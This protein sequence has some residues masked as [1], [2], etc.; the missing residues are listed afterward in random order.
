MAASG[1]M[2]VLQVIFLGVTFGNLSLVRGSATDSNRL[3]RLDRPL[4]SM[5]LPSSLCGHQAG[6]RPVQLFP[7][8]VRRYG[9]T[10]TLS[11]TVPSPP[12]TRLSGAQPLTGR[13]SGRTSNFFRRL[14]VVTLLKSCPLRTLEC[15]KTCLVVGG[16]SA[17][18]LPLNRKKL[19]LIVRLSGFLLVLGAPLA[20]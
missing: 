14:D 10:Q 17:A 18:E 13:E 1:R 11:S 20:E 8:S 3:S 9:R 5:N 6:N 2:R 16:S 15:A 7:R 4:S 19:S 12:P